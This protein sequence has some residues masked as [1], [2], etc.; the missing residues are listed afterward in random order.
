M[1]NIPGYVIYGATI[2]REFDG[3][4]NEYIGV[5]A[6]PTGGTFRFC[7]F[8]NRVNVPLQSICTGTGSINSSGGW[9]AI[10]EDNGAA[11]AEF[12]GG[13]IPGWV[14]KS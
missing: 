14:P 11:G 8:K 12:H 13:L 3:A 9:I 2:T 7:V 6:K 10:T 5:Y 1:A 4:N